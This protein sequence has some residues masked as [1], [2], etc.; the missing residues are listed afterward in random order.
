MQKSVRVKQKILPKS[1]FFFCFVFLERFEK[2]DLTIFEQTRQMLTPVVP[3]H[4]PKTNSLQANP[5]SLS[6]YLTFGCFG[7][8][9]LVKFL[10]WLCE[11]VEKKKTGQEEKGLVTKK[12]RNNSWIFFP[13]LALVQCWLHVARLAFSMLL[14]RFIQGNIIVSLGWLLFAESYGQTASFPL[15]LDICYFL[16]TFWFSEQDKESVAKV[17][18][19]LDKEYRAKN[20]QDSK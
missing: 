7:L 13:S 5:L 17:V 20:G 1:R 19:K 11:K 9:C 12:K 10:S 15:V 3:T 18:D 2:K 4:S 6:F 16:P 8:V 14:Q